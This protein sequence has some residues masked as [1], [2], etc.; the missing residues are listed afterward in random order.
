[1]NRADIME[2]I[3]KLYVESSENRVSADVAIT[4][5]LADLKMYDAP[6]V[7]VASAQDQLFDE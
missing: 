2:A 6:L 1:M 7:G 3:L 5:E 4:P